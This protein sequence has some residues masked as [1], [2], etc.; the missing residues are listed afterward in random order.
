M[1]RKF[2][3][4]IIYINF[5]TQILAGIVQIFQD[6]ILEILFLSS[7]GKFISFAVSLLY[8]SLYIGNDIFTL[9]FIDFNKNY[10][11][12]HKISCYLQVFY[13]KLF[14]KISKMPSFT[15]VM[16]PIFNKDIFQQLLIFYLQCFQVD[17]IFFLIGIHSMQG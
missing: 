14:L 15:S 10:H 6:L 12:S 7:G 1:T 2:K 8:L 13:K 3:L 4:R 9:F 17:E 11:P 16:R 5:L